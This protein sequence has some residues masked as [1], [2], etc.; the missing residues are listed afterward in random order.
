M[1]KILIL[2]FLPFFMIV[3]LFASVSSSGTSN[4]ASDMPDDGIQGDFDNYEPTGDSEV[5]NMYGVQRVLMNLTVAVLYGGR[6]MKMV[7]HLQER[8]L[9]SYQRWVQKSNFMNYSQVIL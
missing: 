7:L 3:I 2:F 9:K 6:A 5:V 4:N 1:K 8:Q